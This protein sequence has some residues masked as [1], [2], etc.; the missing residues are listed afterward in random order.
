VGESFGLDASFG[1]NNYLC[2]F[3]DTIDREHNL[4]DTPLEGCR[5]VFLHEGSP[6]LAYENV[7]PSSLE[8]SH[9]STLCSPPSL[10]SS[11]LDLDAPNDI[12]TIC[13]FNAD[14]G[15]DN[16]M[17]NMLGGNAE[18]FESLG[19]LCGHNAAL[20]PYCINLVDMPRKIMWNTIFDFSF[21]FSMA[22]TLR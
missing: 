7:I 21:D 19:Y 6:S 13:D 8:H 11:E 17:F 20:D 9:V 22:L 4:V 3:E 10:S 1:M 16:N 15:H 5:E 12:S 18:N 14:I 2:G